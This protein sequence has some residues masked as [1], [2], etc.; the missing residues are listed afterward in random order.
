M[1]ITRKGGIVVDWNVI[2]A[3]YIA[4]GTS[5]R[6]LAE[7][8]GIDRNQIADRGKSEKWVELKRQTLDKTQTKLS[9]AIS[10]SAAS[11]AAEAVRLINESALSM[12]KLIAREAAEQREMTES[13]VNTYSRALKNLKDVLDIKSQND[14]DEQQARIDN[15][16]KQA[17]KDET[18]KDVQFVIGDDL[19]EYAV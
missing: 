12:L 9:D 19:E 6:K 17:A 10:D 2:K 3:E 7:K 18:D 4:G 1:G 5:Y 13:K 16:R 14:I 8:Y 11:D 15:L